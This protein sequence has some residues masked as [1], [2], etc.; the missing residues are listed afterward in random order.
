MTD[1]V[2][3]AGTKTEV[4]LAFGRDIEPGIFEDGRIGTGRL[5]EQVNRRALFDIQSLIVEILQRFAGHPCHGRAHA[6]DFFDSSPCQ[7]RIFTQQFPLVRVLDEHVHGQGDLVTRG[8]DA[9]ENGE[10][11][12]VVQF[13][14]A[15]RG[16]V[17]FVGFNQHAEKVIAQAVLLQGFNRHGGITEQFVG[18]GVDLCFVLLE[19]H[20]QRQ[21]HVHRQ[22]SQPSPLTAR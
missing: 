3:S 11:D 9:A 13:L 19:R 18:R 16:F 22:L 21:A 6:H 15:Q 1:A 12:H 8:V 4:R 2:V 20:A 14:I 10:N 7:L 17:F 5:A